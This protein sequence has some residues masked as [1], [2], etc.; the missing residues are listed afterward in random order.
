MPCVNT[1]TDLWSE[2]EQPHNVILVNK[3]FNG[4]VDERA[5]PLGVVFD[6]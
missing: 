1:F 2:K 6:T 5:L 3:L 4:D